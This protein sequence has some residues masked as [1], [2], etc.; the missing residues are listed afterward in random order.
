MNCPNKSTIDWKRL[1][2]QCGPELAM[3]IWQAY[4]E[5]FPKTSSISDL[6]KN[7]GISKRLF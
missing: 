1:E 3:T 6:Y 2:N 5:Q 7:I 4:G